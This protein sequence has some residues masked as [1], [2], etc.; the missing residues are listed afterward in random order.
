MADLTHL[1][2]IGQKVKCLF[3]DPD[4]VRRRFLDGTVTET[5]PDHIIIDVSGVSSHCWYEE[6]LN[7]DS[8]YP[9]YNFKEGGNLI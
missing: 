8:V 6:G 3:D 5:A 7:L 4:D 2:S 1:Y 9:A